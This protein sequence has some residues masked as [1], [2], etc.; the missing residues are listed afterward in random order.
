MPIFEPQ[1]GKVMATSIVEVTW[2]SE[3]KAPDLN[4]GDIGSNFIGCPINGDPINL[5]R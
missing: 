1:T 3:E 2:Q 4:G 5:S